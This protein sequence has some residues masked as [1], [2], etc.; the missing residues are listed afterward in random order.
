MNKYLLYPTADTMLQLIVQCSDSVK[1]SQCS[2]CPIALKLNM[3]ASLNYTPP[4]HTS[5]P[6][7]LSPPYER[8]RPRTPRL[9]KHST[10]IKSQRRKLAA[11]HYHPNRTRETGHRRALDPTI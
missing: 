9:K 6:Y 10:I 11:G 4:L 2:Q 8:G 5:T 7:H 3:E 1:E